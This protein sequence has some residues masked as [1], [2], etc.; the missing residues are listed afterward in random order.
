MPK[1]RKPYDGPVKSKRL[2]LTDEHGEPLPSMTQQQFKD[3]S[4]INNVIRKYDKTGLITHVSAIQAHYGD[5]TEVNEYQEALNIVMKAQNDFASLPAKIRN[6]FHNDPGEFVEFITNPDNL[7][8]MVEL[9]LAKKP[10]VADE[11]VN[12]HVG[13]KPEDTPAGA[14]EGAQA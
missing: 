3:E 7:D 1:F 2:K 9:G 5:F 13:N 12:Q 14:Q 11:D 6:R 10:K 4:D 8:E